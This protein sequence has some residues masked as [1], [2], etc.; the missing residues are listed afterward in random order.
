MNNK[1]LFKLPYIDPGT[2]IAV[3]SGL[4]FLAAIILPFLSAFLLFFKKIYRF[5][6]KHKWILFV[7]FI[8]IIC[9]IIGVVMWTKKESK[10]DKKI[11]I[12]GMDG[13]DPK[14]LNKFM[15]EGILPNFSRLK[16]E[17]SLK[18]LKTTNPS[19]SPVA[20]SSFVTG[21]NPGKHGMFDF[22]RR[23]PNTYKL[24][25]SVTEVKDNKVVCVRKST[26]FWRYTSK[27]KIPTVVIGC[28]VT[29]P[30]EKIYGRMLSGMGVP[31]I[32]GTQGT[33]SFYTTEKLPEDKDI[34]GKVFS[35]KR[36]D[37]MFLKLLGPRKKSISG[38][39]EELSIPFMVSLNKDN[40]ITI[41]LQKKTFTLK[42][43]SW[44]SWQEVAFKIGLFKTMRGILKFY[45]VELEPE[46]KLYVSPINFDPRSPYFNIT[47]PK[48]YSK[49]LAKEIGLFY[50]QGMPY[51]TWAL[52]EKRISEDAFIE[53]IEE[54]LRERKKIFELE[55][56][57]L[58]K[59]ILFCY[60]GTSDIIQHMFWRYID[61][62]HP[63]YQED[64]KSTYKDIIKIWYQKMDETLGYTLERISKDDII[65]VLSDHG[66]NTFRRSVHINTWLR[67]NGYLK[68]ID[69][70]KE[71]GRELLMDVDWENTKAYS[72]GFGAIYINQKGREIKGIVAPGK[73]SE[74]LKE[75]ISKKIKEWIDEEYNNP[76][77]NNVYKREDIFWG[78]FTH[79]T[80]DLYLGFNIGYRA[81]WQSALGAAPSP[82]IEDNLKNWSG[83]HLFDPILIPGIILSNKKIKV[84]DPS[85]CDIIPTIIKFIGFNQNE[86]K[87][88]NFDG[89]PLF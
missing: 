71:E 42:E 24:S 19:Q 5:F 53:Q 2:G 50:T 55:L 77:I 62:E 58:E 75:E 21:Q 51:D 66:F 57:R 87:K 25:L 59:G 46:F 67:K 56:N 88:C 52:N 14:M 68:L 34:G 36:K 84:V 23:D 13:L 31:D 4:G 60:F 28:P 35:I 49:K 1:I 29:F 81:S 41:N 27:L 9:I 69:E 3:T 8:L 63:L 86:I 20:W 33:F 73:E 80:P 54:V 45:L 44:S 16:E 76:I 10:F 70:D 74:D 7:I 26:P 82:L 11:V 89:I 32:L 12:L 17:G 37:R 22:I 43:G 85:I 79:L 48:S 47:Y 61:K 64:A 30:P 15:E 39:S 18:T 72:I 40:S 38:K 83:S 6:K 65:I 78:P